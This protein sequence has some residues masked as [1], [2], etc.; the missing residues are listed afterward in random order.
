MALFRLIF[1]FVLL[2]GLTS[3]SFIFTKIFGIKNIKAVNKKTIIHYSKKYHIPINDSY[4]LDTSYFSFLQSIDTA[5]FKSE[6]KN[7]Y[8]PLQALY[9]NKTETLISFHIN[10]NAGGFPN[11]KWNRNGIMTSFPPKQQTKVDTIIP[12]KTQLKHLTPVFTSKKNLPDSVDYLVIV[13][14]SR[15]MG[16]QSKKLIQQVQKNCQIEPIKK[17][18]I[19]YANNDNVFAKQK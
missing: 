17:I 15:F 10:C 12:L 7:H 13:Y 2:C 5:K 3:C 11:L 4:E 18:K 16:R 19:L 9:Y 1:S 14:W 6:I 8:Q